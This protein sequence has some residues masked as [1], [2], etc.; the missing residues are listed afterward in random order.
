LK[1]VDMFNF[2]SLLSFGN[3]LENKVYQVLG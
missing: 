1:N 3:F 2:K